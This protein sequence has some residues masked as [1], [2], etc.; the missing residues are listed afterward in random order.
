MAVQCP[1][2]RAVARPGARDFA[3]V[4]EEK[5]EGAAVKA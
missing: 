5:R 1:R 3:A 2:R 4:K